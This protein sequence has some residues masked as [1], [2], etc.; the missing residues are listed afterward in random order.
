MRDLAMSNRVKSHS[1]AR[2]PK[3]P[4]RFSALLS[5][6]AGAAL[7]SGCISFGEDPPEQLLTLTPQS[8]IEAGADREGSIG[9]AL[10]VMEPTTSQRLNVN[11]VPVSTTDSSLAYL[12]NAFWVEKP[13]KLFRS[14]L[15]ETIR[16]GGKRFVVDGGDI[17]YAAPVQLTGELVE[18]GYDA[19]SSS[20]VVVFDAML[21]DAS[22][23]LR[24][25]RFE[26]R[27]EGVRAEALDVG[28][29][30]NEAANAVAADVAEWVG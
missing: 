24:T 12:Q 5:A 7:L 6:V 18:M 13:A 10:A 26:H 1:P 11:R 17:I 20:A 23:A 21:M 3:L 19:P 9:A 29:A 16:S 28:R 15:A 4:R 2:T 30:L 25:Q 14:V 8:R 27:V 22:G